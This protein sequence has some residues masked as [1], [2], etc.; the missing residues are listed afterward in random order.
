MVK[1]NMKVSVRLSTN[2][3]ALYMI[4]YDGSLGISKHPLW[5]GNFNYRHKSVA[6]GGFVEGGSVI[7]LRA[8]FLGP[9]PLSP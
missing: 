4:T 5:G 8:K 1:Q 9:Q 3:K 6:D 7:D 2:L